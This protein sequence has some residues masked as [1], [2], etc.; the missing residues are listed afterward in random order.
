MGLFSEAIKMF[1]TILNTHSQEA[2]VL[3]ALG[4]SYIEQGRIEYSTG[5]PLR[6]EKSFIT[7]IKVGLEMFVGSPGFRGIAWKF[8]ADAIFHLS[9]CATLHNANDIIS[10]LQ[11]ILTHMSEDQDNGISKIMQIPSLSSSS[12]LEPTRILEISIFAYSNCITFASKAQTSNGSA[13]YDLAVAL[14]YWVSRTSKSPNAPAAKEKAVDLFIKALKEDPGNAT[15]WVA[16]GNARFASQ[17]KLAQ[18]AYINA[19]ELDSKVN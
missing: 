19:L 3:A 1:K 18:H 12:F 17:P 2:G 7:T 14:D 15:Y 16:L 13:W 11:E 6:A 9:R 10:V 4:R 8:V 5:F